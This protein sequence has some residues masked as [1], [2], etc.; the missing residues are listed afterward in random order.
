MALSSVKKA[1]TAKPA[2]AGDP[3]CDFLAEACR[4]A[5]AKNAYQP[6]DNLKAL[7]CTS[8]VALPVFDA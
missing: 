5:T 8:T 6:D 1:F 4:K 3:N 2:Y 7:V